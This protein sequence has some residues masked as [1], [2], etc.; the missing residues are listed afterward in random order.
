MTIISML[1]SSQNYK[2]KRMLKLF[3]HCFG[4]LGLVLKYHPALL[5][6]GLQIALQNVLSGNRMPINYSTHTNIVQDRTL[7]FQL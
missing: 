7:L 1:T 2:F 6:N 4:I 5:D 3:Q